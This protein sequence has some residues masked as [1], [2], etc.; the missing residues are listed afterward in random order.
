MDFR[1]IFPFSTSRRKPST[2]ILSRQRVPIKHQSQ[3]IRQ[4]EVIRIY[5]SK[6]MIT[7]IVSEVIGT[8][9]QAPLQLLPQSLGC[10]QRSMQPVMPSEKDPL[11]GSILY[12]MRMLQYSRKISRLAITSV[13]NRDCAAL[14]DITLHL[15]GTQPPDLGLS[16]LES[17]RLC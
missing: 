9:Y 3:D 13:L 8:W 1:D 4:E 7:T 11:V 14:K 17:Y 10:S 15:D 2:I 6:V 12:Y 5:L 16:I